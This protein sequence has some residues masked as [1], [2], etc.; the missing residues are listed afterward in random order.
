L[1]CHRDFHGGALPSAA[2]D[3]RWLKTIYTL[4]KGVLD[5]KSQKKKRIQISETLQSEII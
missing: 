1:K 5:K 3:A 4:N 2:A